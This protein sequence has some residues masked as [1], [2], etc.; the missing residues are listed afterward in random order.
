MKATCTSSTRAL[1]PDWLKITKL[2]PTSGSSYYQ[3][4]VGEYAIDKKSIDSYVAEFILNKTGTGSENTIPSIRSSSIKNITT[5]GISNL[6]A[7]DE[8]VV[9]LDCT[10]SSSTENQETFCSNDST[11]DHNIIV[12][13]NV[14]TETQLT[15][16]MARLTTNGNCEDEIV[17]KQTPKFKTAYELRI[18]M[19]C[20]FAKH[21]MVMK[22]KKLFAHC[23]PK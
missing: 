13:N 16:V 10:T 8:E 18:T 15:P 21:L 14:D 3:E 12:H 9:K 23:L 5:N 6:Q 2:P 20:I 1:Q 11:I 17:T 22:R 19:Q 4:G 7:E